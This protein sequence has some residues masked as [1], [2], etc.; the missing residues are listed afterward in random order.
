MAEL[1][2]CRP[3]PFNPDTEISFTNPVA[4]RVR[5][6]VL[7]LRGARVAVLLDEL[8]AP[9]RRSLRWRA[10]EAAGGLYLL[11]LEL[12]GRVLTGKALLVK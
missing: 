12:G 10:G 8:C 5:L 3:N 7:D 9:G 4:Q 2:P 11:R 1:E 6:T